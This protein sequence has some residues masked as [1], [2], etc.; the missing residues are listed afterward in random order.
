MPRITLEKDA[1]HYRNRTNRNRG[2]VL[3]RPDPHGVGGAAGDLPLLR[4]GQQAA[5]EVAATGW[6]RSAGKAASWSSRARRARRHQHHTRAPLPLPCVSGGAD[7]GAPGGAVP[8]ALRRYRHRA[9]PRVA[10]PPRRERESGTAAAVSVGDPGERSDGMA[11][12]PAMGRL[13]LCGSAVVVCAVAATGMVDAKEVGPVG[14]GAHRPSA[15]GHDGHRR[16]GR[17]VARCGARSMREIG[18]GNIGEE[19][20]TKEDPSEITEDGRG[21]PS[22]DDRR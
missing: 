2:Q 3:A 18:R 15:A 9:R 8:E 11:H 19:H 12:P 20:P 6:P 1:E 22:A 10:R 21:F 4:Y 16:F 17:C 13:R 14:A 7:G 5:R